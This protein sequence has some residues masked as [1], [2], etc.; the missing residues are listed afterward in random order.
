[1]ENSSLTSSNADFWKRKLAAF[2]H[3]TPTKCLNIRDHSLKSIEAMRRAGFTE[4]DIARYDPETKRSDRYDHEADWAAA[5]ADRYPFPDS[6]ASGLACAFDGHR[7]K[8][9]HPLDGRH[10]LGFSPIQSDDLGTET[11]QVCQPLL[12]TGES[13]D[14]DFWRD[15][16]FAHWRLWC[17]DAR[18]KDHRLAFLPADTRLADQLAHYA[19]GSGNL[20]EGSLPYFRRQEFNPTQLDGMATFLASRRALS[21]SYHLQFSEALSAFALHCARPIV[22]AFDGR[23]IYAGGDDIV[24]LLTPTAARAARERLS[25]LA[26]AWHEVPPSPALRILALRLLRTHSLRAADAQQLAAALTLALAGLPS[27]AFLSADTR[28]ADAA[29]IEGLTVLR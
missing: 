17:R 29:E 22:E 12:E 15:R 25:T 27:I 18:E 5:A 6:R 10:Q 14:P 4:D 26:A 19:D 24:A 2:L 3:D 21:P 13:A 20:T 16:F 1:M 11:E 9:H 28:L 8:F 23:L 7:N